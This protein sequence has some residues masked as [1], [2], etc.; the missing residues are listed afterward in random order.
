MHRLLVDGVTV[1]YRSRDG[2]IRGAQARVIDFDDPSNDDWLAVNQFAPLAAP[3][4]L[5]RVAD[6][7]P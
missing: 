3:D 1:E 7:L 4:A 5:V 6:L 2:G